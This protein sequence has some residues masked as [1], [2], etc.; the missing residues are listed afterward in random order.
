MKTGWRLYKIF[1]QLNLFRKLP[2][3]K[4]IVTEVS[5]MECDI[6][7]EIVSISRQ[8][9]PTSFSML[10]FHVSMNYIYMLQDIKTTLTFRFSKTLVLGFPVWLHV[11]VCKF[12]LAVNSGS[13][14][15]H[16]WKFASQLTILESLKAHGNQ[17]L[18]L[19]RHTWSYTSFHLSPCCRNCHQ[20]NRQLWSSSL[21]CFC[22]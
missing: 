12:S 22:T 2:L 14:M 7:L 18:L 19:E 11:P 1:R 20:I 9:T 17:D 13:W 5:F 10:I 3:K 8:K 21:Q 6:A 16:G 4:P 15:M